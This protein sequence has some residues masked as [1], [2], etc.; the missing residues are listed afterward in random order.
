MKKVRARDLIDEITM[1]AWRIADPGVLFMDNINRRNI[2]RESFGLIRATNPCCEEALYPYEFYNLG[3]INLYVFV[4]IDSEGNAYFDWEEFKETIRWVYRFLDNVIDVNKYPL[5]K[6]E[7]V[8]KKV[9]KIGLGFMGLADTL[10]ALKIPYNSEEGFKMIMKICENLTYYAMEESIE[11]AKERGV[12]PAYNES[13]YPKGEMPIEGFYHKDLWTLDWEKLREK[14]MKHGIRNAE[15]TSIAPT[16]SISMICDVS[17]GI[18]PQFALVFEKRITAGRFYYTDIEFERQMTELGLYRPEILKKI[19]ENGGSVQGIEEIPE[20]IRRIFVTALDIP[21]WDHVRAQ[22]V[23][24][25][26]ITTSISKTINMPEW[27]TPEDVKNAYLFAYKAGC[28]GITIYRE[29][30]KS[31][32]VIYLPSEVS[33]KRYKETIGL[34]KNKTLEIMEKIG[35]HVDIS[36]YFKE[37]NEREIMLNI[38]VRPKE[39]GKAMEKC[40][41]C[42]ST[43]LV[44]QGG[45]VNCLD[46]GWSACTIA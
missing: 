22:A 1:A 21:W 46:C 44:Y 11:R 9:R 28:K 38:D 13:L 40:P 30:S 16:G 12:F 5:K 25:L 42:G 19:S 23:A 41:V 26:W 34:I 45:C 43:R 27:V 6:I 32:Q 36:K 29:G 8:T 31:M 7:M 3:S 37:N 39:V 4:K 24:Q 18:E 17:S 15:V 33:K 35:I 14:I 2:M 10:F 20:D